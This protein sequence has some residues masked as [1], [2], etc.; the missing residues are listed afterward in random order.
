[1][2]IITTSVLSDRAMSSWDISIGTALALES[3]FKGPKP[4]YDPERVLPPHVDI[5][6]Y[7]ELWINVSTLYRN[8]LGSVNTATQKQV[9]PGEILSVLEYETELIKEIIKQNSKD[10]VKVIYYCV[11][12]TGLEKK[13]PEAK[14]RKDTTEKQ[15][16]YTEQE[17][18]VIKEF[19]K[20]HRKD[21]GI[22]EFDNAIRS[23][24]SS[25]VLMLTHVA[26]DLLSYNKFNTLHL[27]ESHTGK[28]K[29]IS[30]WW[31]KLSNSKELMRI[32]FNILTL[33]IFGDSQIFLPFPI[34]TRK[35]ILQLAE[36]KKWTN[37]TTKERIRLSLDTLK[38]VF[39]AVVLK[40]I[41]NETY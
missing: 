19:L 5:M 22:L 2:A 9:M 18:L 38:D 24:T 36:D 14:I 16:H 10:R 35:Q 17:T 37:V 41:L 29:D 39:A 13:H 11:H 1:M 23:I 33:Q 28:C 15:I 34:E 7:Q 31:T 4:P 3:L 21:N 26:Y 30:L 8:I 20:R 25:N 6:G 27:L 32:P 40:K 12:Y